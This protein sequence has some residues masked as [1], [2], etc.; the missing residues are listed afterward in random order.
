LLGARS[1]REEEGGERQG[2]RFQD[3]PALSLF[4]HVL[5]NLTETAADFH[6]FRRD[7]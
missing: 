2:C 3:H 6:R 7:D 5:L 1:G 4:L